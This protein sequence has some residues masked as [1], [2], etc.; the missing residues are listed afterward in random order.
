MEPR[1]RHKARDPA[2]QA[3]PAK[4]TAGEWPRALNVGLG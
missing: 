1:R 2:R 4:I 3:G